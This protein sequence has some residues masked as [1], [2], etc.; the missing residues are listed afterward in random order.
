MEGPGG[1][2]G[3]LGVLR[4]VRAGGLDAGPE[5]VDVSP[6][7]PDGLPDGVVAVAVSS[8]V[9]VP[10]VPVTGGGV[11]P[12]GGGEVAGEG[13][14]VGGVGVGGGGT[15]RSGS[16]AAPRSRSYQRPLSRS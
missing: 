11:G 12:E 16:G 2:V 9:P 5:G 8:G 7:P 15:G 3:P 4:S 13:V 14:P 1:V 6:G 10:G